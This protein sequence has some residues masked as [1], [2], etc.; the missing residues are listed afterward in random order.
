MT[1]RF[2]RQGGGQSPLSV[3]EY[4]ELAE[5]SRTFSVI[6]AFNIGEVNLTDTTRPASQGHLA[7]F[8]LELVELTGIEPVT[9]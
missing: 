7:K 5:M 1:T 3:P 4:Y 9:S 6:G 2:D 8:L